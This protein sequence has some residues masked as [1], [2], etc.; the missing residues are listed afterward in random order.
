[1]NHNALPL[2]AALVAAVAIAGIVSLEVRAGS[3]HSAQIRLSAATAGLNELQMVPF[4]AEP[5]GTSTGGTDAHML[6]LEEPI[7]ATATDV[8]DAQLVALL[9]RNFAVLEGIRAQA[10][11]GRAG[12]LAAAEQSRLAAAEALARRSAAYDS[13]GQSAQVMAVA[14]SI[15]AI[16]A[17]LG[18]FWLY[19]LR[20]ASVRRRE[21]LAS[22]DLGIARD[23]RKRLLTRALEAA[24]DERTRIAA[25]LHDGPIQRLTAAAFTID[26][27]GRKIARG[28]REL[29]GL[30][31][32]IREQL[33]GEMES[34]RRM[35]SGLR[36]P[37]LDQGDITAAIRDCA[38]SLLD[39]KTT[40]KVRD[41]IG[42][43]F[44]SRDLEAVAFHVAREAIVNVKRHAR[45]SHVAITL[46][47]Q[48][49]SLQLTIVD[50]GAGFVPETTETAR[51]EHHLGLTAMRDR[52][53]SVGG[54]LR[55]VS[56]PGAGTRIDA[57]LPLPQPANGHSAERTTHAAVA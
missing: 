10:P 30:V 2:T 17:L 22:A 25:D 35:M 14:G 6:A 57:I 26:L 41:T 47:A 18:A 52:V 39:P 8:G 3:S 23:E 31:A 43:T 46:S 13:R 19:Y 42:N 51:L 32:Q 49:D 48:G 15:V 4:R 50:D 21:Q 16:V 12:R 20:S 27:L 24:Q 37:Q 9:Q 38:G 36:P 29:D 28:E 44:V 53:E 55:V 54:E 40:H 45:A 7:L 34:L 56:E 33:S 5:A 1:M 11:A